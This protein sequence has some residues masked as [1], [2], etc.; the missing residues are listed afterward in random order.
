MQATKQQAGGAIDWLPDHLLTTSDNPLV[1]WASAGVSGVKGYMAQ[2]ERWRDTNYPA[3]TT[4]SAEYQSSLQQEYG[5][6]RVT[7]VQQYLATGVPAPLSAYVE[8]L[9]PATPNQKRDAQS[10][11]AA[12][13]A[14]GYWDS[15]LENVQSR[16][17]P[18]IAAHLDRH[19]ASFPPRKQSSAGVTANGQAA[20]D[21]LSSSAS[22]AS[23][24]TVVTGNLVRSMWSVPRT[25]Y[26]RSV[27]SQK[28]GDVLPTAAQRDAAIGKLW[29]G[30]KGMG[31]ALW[32]MTTG[33]AR[34]NATGVPGATT[35]V[36]WKLTTGG[37]PTAH[38]ESFLS[39]FLGPTIMEGIADTGRAVRVLVDA[40]LTAPPSRQSKSIT[41]LGNGLRTAWQIVTSDVSIAIDPTSCFFNEEFC[42]DCLYRTP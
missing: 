7:L 6:D 15:F 26:L 1:S 9:Y 16:V 18:S 41:A 20:A 27:L 22:F 39:R 31:T 8:A 11:D 21:S 36:K 5:A 12:S 38:R 37:R 29:R 2:Q 10:N 34:A 23:Y 28:R 14:A 30:V 33:R 3:S 17:L 42:Q 35:S 40:V 32:E 25:V 4:G 19:F 24:S 13:G